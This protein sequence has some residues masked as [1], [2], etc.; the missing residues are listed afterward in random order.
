MRKGRISRGSVSAFTGQQLYSR[1]ET[2]IT[3]ETFA[4]KGDTVDDF[5]LSRSSCVIFWGDEISS[6]ES[7]DPLTGVTMERL[8]NYRIFP[9]QP[10]RN[11]TGA[12][13][14]CRR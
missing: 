13:Q 14:P 3:G 10:L 8:D 2:I 4:M 5:L 11:Y 1:N 6:I 12:D 7:V 9:T